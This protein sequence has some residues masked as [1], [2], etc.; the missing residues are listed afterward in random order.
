MLVGQIFN[1]HSALLPSIVIALVLQLSHDPFIY[2]MVSLDAIKFAQL[3]FLSPNTQ[4][5]ISFV[6][7][8]AAI[9][10]TK[11]TPTHLLA[12]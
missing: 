3:V 10:D 11:P 7:Q 12:H 2:S 4:A 6:V 8:P 5:L 1:L 9:S